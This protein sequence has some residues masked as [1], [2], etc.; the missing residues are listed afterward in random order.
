MRPML[1]TFELVSKDSHPL[2]AIYWEKGEGEVLGN[3]VE[4]AASY[5]GQIEYCTVF[6]VWMRS[7]DYCPH[8]SS[9]RV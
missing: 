9:T 8:I 6:G 1:Q 7:G 2:K 4:I 5:L 3:S